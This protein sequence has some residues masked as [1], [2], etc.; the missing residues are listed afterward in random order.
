VSG[1]R[2]WGLGFTRDAAPSNTWRRSTPACA[3]STLSAAAATA[4]TGLQVRTAPRLPLSDRRSGEMGTV[5]TIRSVAQDVI[6]VYSRHV[7]YGRR[8]LC[9]VS[10]PGVE[11]GGSQDVAGRGRGASF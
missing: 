11:D 4:E 9:V 8:R 1:F 7:R 6:S 3:A 5:G 10:K 2:V